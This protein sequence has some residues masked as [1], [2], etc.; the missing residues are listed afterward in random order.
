MNLKPFI[1]KKLKEQNENKIKF[2]LGLISSTLVLLLFYI[3]SGPEIKEDSLEPES[4]LNLSVMIPDGYVLFGFEAENYAQISPILEPYSMVQVYNTNTRRLIAKNIKVLRAPKDP[5][6]LSFLVP[7]NIA[8]Y[9]ARFGLEY[10]IVLQK[11]DVMKKP[12]IIQRLNKKPETS[13]TYGGTK[14]V[15]L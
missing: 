12:Q 8:N 4:S 10:R 13:I 3:S 14:N 7:V 9:F 11:Y 5:S 2:V 1:Y 6:Q 15:S